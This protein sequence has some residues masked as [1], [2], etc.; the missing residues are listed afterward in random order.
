MADKSGFRGSVVPDENSRSVTRE[1]ATDPENCRFIS[2]AI[3]HETDRSYSSGDDEGDV[4]GGGDVEN[5]SYKDILTPE[6]NNSL[7]AFRRSLGP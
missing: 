7:T 2:Y 6:A 3:T 1:P 5:R 4:D